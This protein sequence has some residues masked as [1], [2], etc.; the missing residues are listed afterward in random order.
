MFFS[1]LFYNNGC[2]FLIKK[3]NLMN[4]TNEESQKITKDMAGCLVLGKEHVEIL[5]KLVSKYKI[6]AQEKYENT[7]DLKINSSVS[8]GFIEL[9]CDNY[10]EHFKDIDELLECLKN[11]ESKSE[12]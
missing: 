11:M 4:I 5:I 1:N 7:F 9:K 3:G 2:I 10:I 6:K 8:M 12:L